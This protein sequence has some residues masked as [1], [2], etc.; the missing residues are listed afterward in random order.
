MLGLNKPEPEKKEYFFALEIDTGRVKS[1][2]WTIEDDQ[3]QLLSLGE[4]VNW[5]KEEEILEAVDT[6]L[7]SAVERLTPSQAGKEPE[8]IIFGL[9]SEWIEENKITPPKAEVLKKIS[10]KLELTPLGFVVIPEAIAHWLKKLEGVPLN[11]VLIGLGKKKITV[12]LVEAGRVME[13]NLV[14]RSENLGSDLTEG[15]SRS[16]KE[17][18]FP[19]RILLYDH[20]EKLE[21]ARQ[22]LINWSWP[23]EKVNFLHLPKVEILSADFDIKSIVLAS[24]SQIAEVKGMKEIEEVPEP[25]EEVVE[26]KEEVSEVVEAEKKEPENLFGFVKN[27]D[28]SQISPQEPEEKPTPVFKPKLD[29]FQNKLSFFKRLN[30]GAFLGSL[31]ETLSHRSLAVFLLIGAVLL[32]LLAGLWSLYWFLPKANI[33]LTVKPK[34]LE[35]DFT[36]KLDPSLSTVDKENLI[37]PASEIQA[38][39]EGEKEANTTGTKLVG[40]KAKGEVTIFNATTQAKTFAKGIIIST[41]AGIEFSLDESVSVASKS[42]TAADSESG[43]SKIKV[44]AVE[45]GSEGNLAAGSEF[46]VSNLAKSDFVAKNESSFSEGSSREIQVVAKADENKLLAELQE[47]LEEKALADLKT[48][49]TSG[50]KLVEESLT[51]QVVEKT[52]DKKVDEEADRV[53]LKLQIEITAL[54][55]QEDEFKQLAEVEIRNLVPSDF[56]YDP[57]KTEIEFEPETSSSKGVFTFQA[58]FKADLVP[59]LNLEEIKKNLLGKKPVIGKTYLNNLPNVTSFEAQISPQLPESI[60][61]FPRLL[62][63]INLEVETE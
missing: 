43:K 40:D 27:Q 46:S 58:R 30:L 50:Q 13:T 19:A 35:K 22:E 17:G 5:E 31:R 1:A 60:A 14:V 57:A 9:S 18:P 41:P 21:E 33:I 4:I 32:V 54:S 49:L 25:K 39:V 38:T 11:A 6:S 28:I 55:F 56:D 52:F 34:V 12:S 44:T 45:I 20:E 24:A 8:K 47:E 51:S 15:L 59:K 23:D 26:E 2:I 53:N 7:S 16:G 29:Y 3:S 48:K 42:G 62:K 36:I 37:L 61:T 63:R 10:Q